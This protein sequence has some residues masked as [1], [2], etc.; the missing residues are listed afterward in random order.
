MK[1]RLGQEAAQAVRDAEECLNIGRAY[2]RVDCGLAYAEYTLRKVQ[3]K[4]DLDDVSTGIHTAA[5]SAEG[6]KKIA[7]PETHKAIDA[8]IN[9]AT[10]VNKMVRQKWIAPPKDPVTK[11]PRSKEPFTERE[12]KSLQT[13]TENLRIKANEIFASMRGLCTFKPVVPQPAVSPAR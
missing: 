3:K 5:R 2:T 8:F 6:L 13:E 4:V 10:N 9:N 12:F 11:K 7:P 1:M